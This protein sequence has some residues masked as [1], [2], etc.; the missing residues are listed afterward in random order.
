MQLIKKNIWLIVDYREEFCNMFIVSLISLILILIGAL[1]WG[2]I[3]LFNYNFV[4]AIIGNNPVGMYS[5]FARFIYALVGLAGVWG[6]SFLGLVKY[7]PGKKTK[8]PGN[9]QK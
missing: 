5:G 8:P 4:N 9:D 2:S 6:I 7:L 3:G 1:N